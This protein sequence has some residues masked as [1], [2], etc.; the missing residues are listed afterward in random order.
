MPDEKAERAAGH[1]PLRLVAH[2]ARV[3]QTAVAGHRGTYMGDPA[4]GLD[5]SG[6]CL[7]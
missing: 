4:S 5:R 3:T 2:R 1:L 7:D 6:K